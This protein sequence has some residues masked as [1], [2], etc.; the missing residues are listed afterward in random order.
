M[1]SYAWLLTIPLRLYFVGGI[2]LTM[3]IRLFVVFKLSDYI[4]H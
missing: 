3:P 2:G 1:I 4:K